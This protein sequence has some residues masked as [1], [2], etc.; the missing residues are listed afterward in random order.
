MLTKAK[1][2]KRDPYLA[3]LE[4]RNTPIDGMGTPAQLLMSRRLR[5]IVPNTDEQL[6]PKVINPKHVANRVSLKQASQKDYFDRHTKTLP[7]LEQ[8]ERVRVRMGKHWKP[9]VVKQCEETPRSYRIKT[10]EAGEYRRNRRMIM[11]SRE[12]NPLATDDGDDSASETEEYH[13]SEETPDHQA[14]SPGAT[15]PADPITRTR[16]GRVV[17]RPQ[18]FK[19]FVPYQ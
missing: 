8:G 18:R 3:L 10:D 9:G 19:D 6:K 5:S 13:S 4:Y 16:S 2:D 14:M 7:P 1:R 17:R 11:K 12:N 15:E